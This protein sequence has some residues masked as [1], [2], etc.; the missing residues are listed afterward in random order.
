[1][2]L[3]PNLQVAGKRTRTCRAASPVRQSGSVYLASDPPHCVVACESR[4]ARH[5]RGGHRTPLHC[6]SN[7][8]SFLPLSLSTPPFEPIQHNL[9]K[10]EALFAC[11]Q[12]VHHGKLV[13]GVKRKCSLCFA[14]ASI[15]MEIS[16]KASVIGLSIFLVVLGMSC[17]ANARFLFEFCGAPR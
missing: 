8:M 10:A 3:Q 6:R 15:S 11:C 13:M 1:M 17:H 4:A 9:V 5:V 7:F 14:L 16:E 2:L 12:P